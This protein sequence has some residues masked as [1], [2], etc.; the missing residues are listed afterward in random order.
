MEV[1]VKTAAEATKL[2]GTSPDF[3]AFVAERAGTPDASGCTNELTIL[4]FHPD[5]FA[6]GQEF[7]PGCGGSQ[8]IWGKQDGQWAPLL[9]MQSVVECTDMANNDI[10]RGLPDIPCLDGKDNVVNW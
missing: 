2:T 8:N 4:A 7:A 3:Q 9:V 5:G 10:P 1:T 6:A